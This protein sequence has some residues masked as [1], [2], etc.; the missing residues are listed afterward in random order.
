MNTPGNCKTAE[1]ELR[2]QTQAKRSRLELAKKLAQEQRAGKEREE[3][4]LQDCAQKIVQAQ[5]QKEKANKERMMVVKKNQ[6]IIIALLGYDEE[7]QKKVQLK[8]APLHTLHV[9]DVM[10]EDPNQWGND[11]QKTQ[12]YMSLL[13]AS[14]ITEP[15]VFVVRVLQFQT[16]IVLQYGSGMLA[17]AIVWD[18]DGKCRWEYCTIVSVHLSGV[19]VQ[20]AKKPGSI[21]KS[22]T[23]PRPYSAVQLVLRMTDPFVSS[24]LRDELLELEANRLEFIRQ[25]II[26]DTEKI[27]DTD[28]KNQAIIHKNNCQKKQALYDRLEVK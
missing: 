3:R 25:A 12:E 10:S 16:K 7:M 26:Q 18:A 1:L 22:F 4:T 21:R 8:I 6:D 20:F 11:S 17:T 28:E 19:R 27:Q 23:K 2:E 24:C 14:L 5:A 13:T 15:E 9:Y